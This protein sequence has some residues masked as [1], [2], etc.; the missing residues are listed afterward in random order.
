MGN[1]K[2]NIANWLR[3]NDT[4]ILTGI[5]IAEGLGF[6]SFLWYQTGKKV[7]R[8][9]ESAKKQKGEDLT[10]KEKLKETWKMLV[11]PSIVT[12]TSMALLIYSARTNNKKLA[13]LGAAY[14]LTETAFQRYINK[15]K[16]ELG[17]K[18]ANSI[19]E[20]VSKENIENSNNKNTIMLTGDGE[21]W[22]HEPL[23]DRMIKTTWSKIQKAANELNA[24]A[25]ASVNGYISLSE[26]F[27]R[28]GLDKTLDSDERGWNPQENSIID[29]SLDSC[30]IN[31]MPCG[32]IRYNTRPK[33]FD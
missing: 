5:G 9:L 18:K 10:F 19:A 16:E 26:W 15:T 22:F 28:L 27:Y 3:K 4:N 31:D 1:T 13:A 20:K 24:E 11:F 33:Y 25:L 17:E 23:T 29:I 7:E 12:S 32:E 8:L 14:N 2:S 21:T 30:L 6:G